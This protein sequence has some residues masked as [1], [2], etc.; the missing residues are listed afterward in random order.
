MADADV[1]ALVLRNGVTI[2]DPLTSAL[3]FIA[4]DSSYEKYEPPWRT[5]T[6]SR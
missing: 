1:P 4:H 3:E 2:D 6:C 5:T